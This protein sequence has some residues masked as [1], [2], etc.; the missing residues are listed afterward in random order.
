MVVAI[1]MTATL[2][3]RASTFPPLPG[4]FFETKQAASRWHRPCLRTGVP[5]TPIRSIYDEPTVMWRMRR[6]DGQSSHLAIAPREHGVAVV[7]FVNGRLLGLRD[8]DDVG[9]AVRCSEQMQAQNW[10]AGWRVES[11]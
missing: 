4:S 3:F 1:A 10:V 11:E 7:W 8:F 6:A 5:E 9:S 2:V